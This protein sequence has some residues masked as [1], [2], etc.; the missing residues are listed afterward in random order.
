MC[1]R[2]FGRDNGVNIKTMLLACQSFEAE[3]SVSFPEVFTPI[4][5]NRIV[6]HRLCR[7]L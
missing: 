5:C 4:Y 7:F 6:K 2:V 1:E 3:P